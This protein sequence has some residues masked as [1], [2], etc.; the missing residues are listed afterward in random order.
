[1]SILGPRCCDGSKFFQRLWGPMWPYPSPLQLPPS[2]TPTP[3]LLLQ[4]L[5]HT[6][7]TLLFPQ[8]Y[9]WLFPFSF[10]FL[11]SFFLF[12]FLHIV[13]HFLSYN[14]ILLCLLFIIS[15]SLECEFQEGR[16]LVC[17]VLRWITSAWR[18]EDSIN[19]RWTNEKL[20]KVLL[21]W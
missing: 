3:V 2:L 5:D 19:I 12:P 20:A 16:S 1:M 17:F 7:S 4:T 21:G 10:S 11:L 8:H 15:S 18:P 9:L 13:G 6:W 14:V